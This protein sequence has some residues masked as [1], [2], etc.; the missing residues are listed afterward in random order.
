[1]SVSTISTTSIRDKDGFIGNAGDVLYTNGNTIYWAPSGGGGGGGYWKEGGTDIWNNNSGNVGINT[2]TPGFTLDIAGTTNIASSLTVSTIVNVN[3]ISTTNGQIIGLTSNI[4]TVNTEISTAQFQVLYD[5]ELAPFKGINGNYLYTKPNSD[6]YINLGAWSTGTQSAIPLCLQVT[7]AGGPANSFVGINTAYP[8]SILDVNGNTHITGELVV[9]GSTLITDDNALILFEPSGTNGNVIRY[10]GPGP[11]ANNLIFQGAGNFEKMRINPSGYVGINTN[12]PQYNLDI[13]NTLRVEAGSNDTLGSGGYINQFIRS[14]SSGTTTVDYQVT[15]DGSQFTGTWQDARYVYNNNNTPNLRQVWGIVTSSNIT[16]VGPNM[17]DIHFYNNVYIDKE[18]GIGTTNPQAFLHIAETSASSY[19]EFTTPGT[20]S[21]TIPS[22]A[23]ELEFEMVG[24]GGQGYVE[25]AGSGGY[26][27]GTINVASFQGQT[28]TIIVGSVGYETPPPISNSTQSG[29]TYIYISGT[30]LFAMCGAGGGDSQLGGNVNGG[31]GGGGTFT[32]VSGSDWVAAGG[33][34]NSVGS[35]TAGGGGQLTTGGT[36]G[37]CGGS[38]PG[39][40]GNDRN[41]PTVAYMEALGGSNNTTAAGGNGYTGGGSGCAGGGGS[42]YYN[43]TYTTIITSYSGNNIPSSTLP[44]YGRSGKGGYVSITF[45]SSEPSIVTNGAVGIGT[46]SP[47]IKLQTIIDTQTGLD[48]I[49][50]R[51]S[52]VNTIIGAYSEGILTGTN[53]GSIQS[54]RLGTTFDPWVL[55]FNPRGGDIYIGSSI[56]N[57]YVLSDTFNCSNKAI[58]KQI[59]TSPLTTDIGAGG[60][61][62][63][64]YGK[65]TF[66]STTNTL[67]LP[68]TGVSEGSVLIFRNLDLGQSLTINNCF[69]GGSPIPPNGAASFIFTTVYGGSTWISM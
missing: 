30:T 43:S 11:N 26:I 35:S 6:G 36:A 39:V 67:T 61:W 1:M 57:T 21:V 32:N 9:N 52:D 12:N 55:T 45:P 40:P 69:T 20:Y 24:A 2:I 25:L 17:G 51:S 60:P 63:N 14:S 15:S 3:S 38:F 18:V 54:T 42:S 5:S 7:S 41:P 62:T 34:G 65:Y 50:T 37:N 53:A 16:P 13:K 28:I 33:S 64:Y 56:A 27:K 23:I 19:Q 29:A 31:F 4:L 49:A 22:N 44:S 58:S 59:V 47:Y 10:G 48:G 66:V 8:S 68:T 46:T